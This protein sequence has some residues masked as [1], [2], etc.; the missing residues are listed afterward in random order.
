MLA[1]SY[2]IDCALSQIVYYHH[3]N[4]IDFA[5]LS[6]KTIDRYLQ[7]YQPKILVGLRPNIDNVSEET[8]LIDNTKRS[9]ELYND[10]DNFLYESKVSKTHIFSRY[11][12]TDN[13]LVKYILLADALST[14]QYTEQNMLFLDFYNSIGHDTFVYKFICNDNLLLNKNE[15][16]LALRF[17]KF[18]NE[19]ADDFISNFLTVKDNVAICRSN[20][21]MREAIENAI[22]SKYRDDIFLIITW[23]Y[24]HDTTYRISMCSKTDISGKIAEELKGDNYVRSG[25]CKLKIDT[26]IEDPSDFI[27]EQIIEVYNNVIQKEQKSLYLDKQKELEKYINKLESDNLFDSF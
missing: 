19:T 21:S 25:T 18:Q 10:Y 23:D 4:Q 9:F 3:T 13:S 16:Q 22:L 24:D 1:T 8:I 5:T 12:K 27:Y 26:H 7:K 6:N 20:Y 11:L 14:G 15:Q 2:G 17:R